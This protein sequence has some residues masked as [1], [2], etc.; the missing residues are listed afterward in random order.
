MKN[1]KITITSV[2]IMI[3]GLIVLLVGLFDVGN[4]SKIKGSIS[5]ETASF[6]VTFQCEKT[7]INVNETTTCVTYVDVG[8]NTVL[9]VQGAISSGNNISISNLAPIPEGWISQGEELMLSWDSNK[10]QSGN[11]EVSSFTIKGEQAGTTAINMVPFAD[12]M[13]VSDGGESQDH[14]ITSV[15]LTITVK[16]S[17]SPASTVNTLKS[18]TVSDGTLT[19]EF[20]KDLTNY[21]VAVT[22]NVDTITVTA[23][24]TDSAATVEGTGVANLDIG[25]NTISIVVTPEEG[26]A[27]TYNIVVTRSADE[28][29]YA[30]TDLK[31]IVINNGT[32]VP[33]FNKD[34]TT[35]TV[36]VDASVSEIGISV[37]PAN[38][39]STV[40]GAGTKAI[41]GSDEPI[42]I[43]VTDSKGNK[44]TYTI[45][46]VRK[47]ADKECVLSSGNY[48][49]DN[50]KLI[51]SKVDLN[52]SDET[53]TKRLSSTCGTFKVSDNKVVLSYNGKTKTYSIERSW[54]PKTG[55]I[56]VNY[57]AII[58]G[59]II[60]I[61]GALFVFAKVKKQDK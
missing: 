12:E 25:D 21:T 34:V 52:D 28:E 1:N 55:T 8:S 9:G 33:A 19:P 42:L 30:D 27:K 7:T 20:D 26:D 57:I 51:V 41:T 17:S 46:I 53:I 31:N 54:T 29:D 61:G 18:L 37:E 60:L 11:F 36:E 2:I 40:T 22:N 23:E 47:S 39:T 45:S 10:A 5:D 14:V 32:L 13:L 44:K 49:I 59:I 3:V 35:Y 4:I 56:R 24:P 48:G 43:E 15:P 6:Q 16:D 50:T 38:S 58:G